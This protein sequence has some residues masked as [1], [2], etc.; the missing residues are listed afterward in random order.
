MN[1]NTIILENQLAIMEA[2]RFLMPVDSDKNINLKE[3]IAA[4]KFLI[5]ATA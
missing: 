5:V 3:R 1:A 4:T 2:L